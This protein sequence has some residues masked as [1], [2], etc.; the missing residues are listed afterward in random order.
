MLRHYEHIVSSST[1]MLALLNDRFT[2][3]AANKVYVDAFELTPE[4][5]IGNTVSEVFG[6]DFFDSVIKPNAERCL[7]GEEVNYQDWFNFPVF[8]PRFMDITYY[9][10]YSE[11]N[12]IIGFVVNGR[13]ITERKQAEA[14]LRKSEQ[15]F[16]YPCGANPGYYLYRCVGRDKLNS[17][18]KS[19][20]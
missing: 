5:L 9:P 13:N 20:G 3:L 14:A 1:D 17:L 15:R 7:G 10:Y 4:Q 12:K 6:E 8:E 16:R 19:S 18:Y 11:N 2:Y